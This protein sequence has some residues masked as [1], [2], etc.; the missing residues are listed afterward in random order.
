MNMRGLYYT[1]TSKAVTESRLFHRPGIPATLGQ[2]RS[3]DQVVWI[4]QGSK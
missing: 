3:I 1:Q 2:S 4:W